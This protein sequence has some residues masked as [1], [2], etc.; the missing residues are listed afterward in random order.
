MFDNSWREV[1]KDPDHFIGHKVG[2]HIKVREMDNPFDQLGSD[3]FAF[4]FDYEN[5]SSQ[6]IF[7][8]TWPEQGLPE[9]LDENPPFI[10]QLL[11]IYCPKFRQKGMSRKFLN[12][13][14]ITRKDVIDQKVDL[15][16]E[17]MA[18]F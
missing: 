16:F 1:L 11:W 6:K 14:G 8:M 18:V 3:E 10:D 12:D 17:I 4:K 9:C 5:Y 2:Y 13:L 15:I 7:W